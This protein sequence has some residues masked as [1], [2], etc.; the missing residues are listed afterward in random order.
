VRRILVIG[1]SGFLG[2]HVT[3][4][5]GNWPGVEVLA[6]TRRPR[7]DRQEILIDL[8]AADDDALDR[9]LVSVRPDVVVNCS[10][11][12]AGTRTVLAEANVLAVAR[13]LDAM[14]R[15]ALRARLI[16]LGSAA[17]YGRV[18]VGTRTSERRVPNPIGD[19]GHTKLAAT[20]LVLG[21]R[22][23]GLE[24]AVVLRLFNVLGPRI[25]DDTVLGVAARELRAALASNVGSVSLGPLGA[26][27]DFVDVR[28]VARVV[29]LAATAPTPPPAI[30]N[31]GSG[32][33][34][35]VR[36]V[37]ERLFA[38][39]GFKGRLIERAS[40]GSFRSR[41]VPWQVAD[42]TLVRK[43]LDWSPAIPLAESVDQTW[44][45]L[46]AL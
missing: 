25:T 20:R 19:Y 7:G 32:Q 33:G 16:H 39:A 13:L 34:V 9:T 37:V 36:E 3:D 29:A 1:A 18:T 4:V 26:V 44:T 23:D 10:G 45:S 40:P 21:A 14:G 6:A 35:L 38:T 8:G 46:A 41:D 42:V 31:I 24:G 12:T 22:A 2:S 15:C 30:L 28:D 17:E 43:T 27:R 11:R 5:L